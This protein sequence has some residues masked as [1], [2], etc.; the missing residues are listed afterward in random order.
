MDSTDFQTLVLEKLSNVEA[1]L[2]VLRGRSESALVSYD[3]IR[4][5]IGFKGCTDKQIYE[6]LYRRH[7]YQVS[8]GLYSRAD[9]E[10]LSK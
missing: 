5:N 4:E 9:L 2:S 8:K 3:W 1:E 7:I 6:R 10:K